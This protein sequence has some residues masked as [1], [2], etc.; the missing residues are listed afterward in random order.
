MFLHFFIRRTSKC[1]QSYSAAGITQSIPIIT[2]YLSKT[3]CFSSEGKQ[4]VK[5]SDECK[6]RKCEIKY[7]HTRR[8]RESHSM[9]AGTGKLNV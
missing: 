7:M 3:F 8:V 2:G 9:T 6:V 1:Q 4:T 5:L